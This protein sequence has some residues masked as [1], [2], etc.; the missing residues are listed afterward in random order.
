M[1][2][3]PGFSPHPVDERV[4][5][6][7]PWIWDETLEDGRVAVLKLYPQRGPVSWEREK[8]FRFR[9]EREYE[10]LGRL[11]AAGVPCARPLFWSYGRHP[12]L[13]RYELLA[14]QK[15]RGAVPLSTWVGSGGAWPSLAGLMPHVRRMHEGGIFH[16]ALW[17]KNVLALPGAGADVRFFLIDMPKAMFFAGSIVGSRMAR[18][19]LLDLLWWVRRERG[20]EACRPLVAAYGLEGREEAAFLDRLR[21]HRPTRFTRNRQR[22]EFSVRE[23]LGRR[24]RPAST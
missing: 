15:L 6:H 17:L 1:R 20:L 7:A 21:R 13:G 14:T 12:H 23:L 22:F 3:R 4:P 16:G 11:L 18:V 9:V 2:Q 24:P 8:R 19:D 5:E 10:G